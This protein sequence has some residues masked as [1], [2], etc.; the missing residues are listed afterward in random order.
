MTEGSVTPPM[1]CL[2]LTMYMVPHVHSDSYGLESYTDKQQHGAGELVADYS[3]YEGCRSIYVSNKA[4][5][6]L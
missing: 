4:G 5:N 3:S 1:R 2:L 6:Q